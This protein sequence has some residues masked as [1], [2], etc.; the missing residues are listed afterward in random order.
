MA[1]KLIAKQTCN[2]GKRFY[3]GDEIPVDAV[4]DP[5]LQE[6]RGVLVIVNDDDGAAAPAV[7]LGEPGGDVTAIPVIIHAKEGDMPLSLSPEDIQTIVDILTSNVENAEPIVAQ[8][9]NGDALI[10][11]DCVDTRKSI[12]TAAKE[13]AM[14]L[15]EDSTEPENPEESEGD[16]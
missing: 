12:K 4:L 14:A 13:Q 5:H 7:D 3:I 6:K 9:T 11:L 1:M 15:N 8:M 2:F 10:L 16:Q